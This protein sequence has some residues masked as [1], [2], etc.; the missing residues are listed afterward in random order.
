MHHTRR[1]S[2]C[3]AAGMTLACASMS[4]CAELMP[5]SA[6]EQRQEMS[7]QIPK[8]TRK[9]GSIAV[10][11]PDGGTHWWTQA[12]LPA[13][14]KLIKVYVN[15]SGCFNLVDRG[16]G[17]DI[18]MKERALAS[19]G[20]LR[21]QSSVGKGQIKAAD[22]I[23]IPDYISSNSDAGGGGGAAV[24]GGLLGGAAGALVS[25][26]KFKSRTADVVLTVTD[27]RS[28]EQVAM[29]EGSYKKTD[30]SFGAAGGLFGAGGLGSAAVGGYANTEI[31][32]VIAL[33]Y[34]QAYTDL[35][36]EL[37]GLPDDAK[38]ANA[39]QSVTVG[40]T[41]KLL[42]R[43]DGGGKPVRDLE[44]GVLLF[45]TGNKQGAMWEVEDEIGN[46]GWISSTVLELAK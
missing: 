38:A 5:K 46:R 45:P 26:I 27:V 23:L 18:A 43:A 4:G 17:M 25:N 33:A 10:H 13:P 34:L 16:V 6:Q 9:L 37:G 12:Q 2:T 44:P 1:L 24:I 21:A 8:C 35:I 28:S 42:A 36:K 14:S 19:D 15:K 39:R 11:E 29:V 30:I 32:Q 40:K 20:Q 31:G 41:G 22:Y 7:A 3:L